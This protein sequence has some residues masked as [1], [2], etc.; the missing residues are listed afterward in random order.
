MQAHELRGMACERCSRCEGLWLDLEVYLRYGDALGLSFPD[1]P[2][3]PVPSSS[4]RQCLRC[5]LV[6]QVYLSTGANIPLDRCTE[7]HG[8]WFDRDEL[9][10]FAGVLSAAVSGGGWPFPG[11][12]DGE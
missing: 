4:K 1:P 5:G 3:D 7:A 11:L 2:G 12:W 9:R 8:L 6:M 10:D